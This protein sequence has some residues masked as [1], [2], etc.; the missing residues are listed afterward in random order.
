MRQYFPRLWYDPYQLYVRSLD[1]CL[2]LG[3]QEKHPLDSHFQ[4]LIKTLLS[5]KDTSKCQNRPPL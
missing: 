4:F 1:L 5:K 2:F 3:M